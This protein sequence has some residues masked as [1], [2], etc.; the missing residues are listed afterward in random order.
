MA[1]LNGIQIYDESNFHLLVSEPQSQ[2]NAARPRGEHPRYAQ[3]GDAPFLSVK[4]PQRIPRNEWSARIAEMAAKKERVSD[5]IK[6][7]SKDQKQ[8]NFCW[9]NGPCGAAETVRATMGL[10]YKELSAASVACKLNGFKNQG[11]WGIDAIQYMAKQGV[12]EVKFWPNT[13]ISRQYDTAESNAD[14]PEHVTIGWFDVGND[15]DDVGTA[16][17]LPSPGTAGWNFWGHET[18][19][20]DLVEIGKNSFGCLGRNSWADD[21]GDK[22][23]NGVGGFFILAESKGPDD[24]QVIFQQVASEN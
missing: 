24:F 23:S 22:N 13:A 4:L 17:L 5:A 1:K 20:C 7:P 11:G 3:R 10:G 6:W 8:T 15:F 21:W 14:R 12:C 16:L 9:A 19:V 2:F 18:E